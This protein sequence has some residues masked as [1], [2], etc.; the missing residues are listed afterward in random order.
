MS[1]PM[2]F[3][4]QLMHV[5]SSGGLTFPHLLPEVPPLGWGKRE[6]CVPRAPPGHPLQ[7]QC[8]GHAGWEQGGAAPA[9]WATL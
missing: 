7:P 8:R 5:A 4:Q 1:H 9:G 2:V 6:G 3:G